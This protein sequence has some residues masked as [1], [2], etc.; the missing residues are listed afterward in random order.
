MNSQSVVRWLN[1]C[2]PWIL[3]SWCDRCRPNI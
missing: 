3:W 1:N 2:S